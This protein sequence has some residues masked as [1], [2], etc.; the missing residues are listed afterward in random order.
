[1]AAALTDEPRAGE[2]LAHL[3]RNYHLVG[4]RPGSEEPVY[5]YHPLLRDFL[6]AR[7]EAQLRVGE[8]RELRRRAGAMLESAGAVDEAVALL[9]ADHDW[10]ELARLILERAPEM[11]RRG[12]AET[13]DQWLEE[14]P[15]GQMQDDPWFFY[16]RAACRFYTGPRDSR[17]LYE[18][19]LE[20]FKAAPEPDRRG[21][22]LTCSGAM[23]AIIYEL[24][25]LSLLDGWIEEAR[26][27]LG[28]EPEPQ[29]PAVHARAIVSLFLSLVFRQPQHPDLADWAGRAHE[30]LHAIEDDNARLTAQ[31]LV[32]ITLNYTGQFERVREFIAAMRKACR[33]PHVPPLAVKVLNDVES[34]Y[35]M[36]TADRE[37]CLKAVYDGLEVGSSTGVR[38]WSYHLLSNGAAGA[39]GTG[40]LDA[41]E[42]LLDKMREHQ[43]SARRLDLCTF[44][45]YCAWLAMLRRDPVSA[46]RE[47]K[48]A[49]GLAIECGCPFYEV[50]CRIAMAQ[51]LV[52]LD[53]ERRAFSHLVRARVLGRDIK[54]RLLEFHGLMA[55]AYIALRVGRRRH[56][57]SS[58]RR[59][60]TVG[61][62]QGYAHF[63]WW[64]PEMVAQLCAWA[65]EEGIEVDYVRGL[66]EARELMPEEP[67]VEVRQWPWRFQIRSL[68]DFRVLK[69]GKRLGLQTKL[70]QKPMQLLK[71]LVGFGGE[72]V[73]E[74]RL[75]ESMWPRIDADY[76]HRSLTTTLHRLRKLLGEDRAIVLRHGRLTL[77]PRLCWLDLRA[78]ERITGEV[79]RR[80]RAGRSGVDAPAV[81]SLAER[82][83]EVYRGPFM[84]SEGDHPR[85]IALRGRLRNKFLRYVGELARFWEDRG[86][87][88]R[89][90][91][92][93]ERGIEADG[94]AEGLYRHLMLCHRELGRAAEAVDVY[95]RLRSILRAERDIEPSP[96]ITSIYEGLIGR[97]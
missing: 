1:M 4:S 42:E 64:Q 20:L 13:L 15:E 37:R 60:L 73:Q 62:E 92:Y 58:L 56:A 51:V 86:E 34:M 36:L 24:D 9:R 72:D 2:I 30:H 28:A 12:R 96:E 41:A 81:E 31:L 5:Q 89:A 16:W 93:F 61:R 88:E 27:L 97:L 38:L 90:A 75:A 74:S 44:H 3:H 80:L 94:L 21:L 43:E 57:L 68:G 69:G 26:A 85:Y 8:R 63:L 45:Y 83:L 18:R 77:E 59:A 29:W 35:Y 66:I 25:D 53:D 52:E 55:F 50:L 10:G 19:A 95:D 84:D 49:L 33:S 65:L 54:N 17:R 67:P 71:A 7:A 11:L 23:D 79:D 82:L 78:F 6:G 46:F 91:D 76:A 47:Q 39:L 48:L 70:Q 14:L 22:L 87:W 40:D 32:A